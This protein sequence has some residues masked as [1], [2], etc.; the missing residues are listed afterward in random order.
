MPLE[1]IRASRLEKLKKL[2]EAN[3]DPYPAKSWRT[4]TISAV[5]EGFDDFVANKDRLVLVGRVMAMRGHGAITFMDLQD[6]SG[7]IQVLFKNQKPTDT[8][9]IGDFIEVFGV[10]FTTQKGEKTLEVEKYRMLTKS[11]LPLPEK[12]HGLQDV[13]ERFRKRYLDLL[14]NPETRTVFEKRAQII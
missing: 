12:W 8:T 3:I 13:E 4:H 9:D 10:L 14:M 7:T 6:E 11:L 2:R 1:D 5:L